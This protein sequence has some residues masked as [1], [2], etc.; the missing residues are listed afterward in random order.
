MFKK[1][2][3]PCSVVLFVVLSQELKKKIQ[4]KI[5][6]CIFKGVFDKNFAYV[7]ERFSKVILAWKNVIL[8]FFNVF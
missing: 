3:V 8:I 4:K 7:F 6:W 2:L 5:I 1:V